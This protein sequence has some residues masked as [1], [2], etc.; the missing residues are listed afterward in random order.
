MCIYC[1]RAFP[2]LQAVRQHMV[3]VAHLK[4]LYE[5]ENQYEYEAFYDFSASYEGKEHVKCVWRRGVGSWVVTVPPPPPPRPAEVDDLTGELRLGDGRLLGHRQY[6][7][8]YAQ[9][10]QPESTSLAVERGR[11]EA[12]ERMM[13][14]AAG[15][16]GGAAGAGH[17]VAA[18]AGGRSTA[19]VAVSGHAMARAQRAAARPVRAVVPHRAASLGRSRFPQAEARRQ[20]AETKNELKVAQHKGNLAKSWGAAQFYVWG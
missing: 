8:Y 18:G 13:R 1:N 19:L 7:R 4:M 16:A 3:D 12:F 5:E 20:A 17:L 15:G 2:T 10:I 11:S 6:R 9:N 14:Q